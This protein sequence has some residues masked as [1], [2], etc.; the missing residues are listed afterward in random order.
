LVDGAVDG[1]TFEMI[2]C[3]HAARSDNDGIE[4]EIGLGGEEGRGSVADGAGGALGNSDDIWCRDQGVE[5]G[6]LACQVGG[7]AGIAQVLPALAAASLQVLRQSVIE[8]GGDLVDTRA[9]ARD[10]RIQSGFEINVPHE[11]DHA[12][13]QEILNCRI[14]AE[15]HLTINLAVERVNCI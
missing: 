11:P 7:D 4:M 5:I 9:E 3:R 14:K 6:E 8:S 15:L 1:E 13:E 2:V 10:Y 12:G